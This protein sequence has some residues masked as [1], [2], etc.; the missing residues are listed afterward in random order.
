MQYSHPVE[1][2]VVFFFLTKYT[3]ESI[4]KVIPFK[5]IV[6]TSLILGGHGDVFSQCLTLIWPELTR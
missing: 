2:S 1:I 4:L 5:E 6:F 3:V